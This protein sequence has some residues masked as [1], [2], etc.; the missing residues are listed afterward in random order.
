MTGSHGSS[1]REHLGV[2]TERNFRLFF[3]GYSTSL[4][5]AAMV[6]VALTFAVLQ[7]GGSTNDVGY[8]LAAQTVPLVAL[9]LAGGVLADRLPR[10]AVMVSADLVRCGSQLLL[11]VLLI[12][13]SPPLWVFMVLAGVLG[14]GQALFNPALTGLIPQVSSPGRLQDANALRGLAGSTGQIIGPAAAGLIVAV[15]GAGW[16]IAIDAATYA[17]SAYCLARLRLP[18]GGV[19]SSQTFLSQLRAGWQ[20][21]RSRTWLWVIVL[22]FSLFHL[23]AYAPFMVLG[24]VV[25]RTSLGGATAWGLILTAQGVGA[26]VGGL[27]VLSVRP[28]RPLVVATLGTVMFALPTALLAIPASTPLIAAAAA[29]SGAGMAVFAALWDTSLQ[30]EVPAVALSRVS[31]YDWLGSTAL[32]PIGYA[33]AGPL[34]AALGVSGALWL[35]VAWMIASTVAVLAVPSVRH[36]SSPA[37]GAGTSEDLGEPQPA[38]APQPVDP[39]TLPP[40]STGRV[41]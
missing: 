3:T 9:L 22:Q 20:E 41:R 16:A 18:T 1:W 34:A 4:V 24:A 29:V 25:T 13:G 40:A 21:F 23:V 38:P 19:P 7:E 37:D 27:A 10:K 12:T 11:A 36:L 28:T 15:G 6:P 26:L 35:A 17:V 2:L 39:P 31:A 32:I 14:A 5:G 8:V 33:V 30:R